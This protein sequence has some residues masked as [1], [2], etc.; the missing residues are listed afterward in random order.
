MVTRKNRSLPKKNAK[1]RN[2]LVPVTR[3]GPQQKLYSV[4]V[5]GTSLVLNSSAGGAIATVISAAA[6]NIVNWS[7]RFAS[8]FD[9]YR[10]L[11][12]MWKVTP[13]SNQPGLT[14]FYVDEN[15]SSVPTLTESRN[16]RHVILSNSNTASSRMPF[17][18]KWRN[19]DLSDLGFIATGTTSTTPAVLKVYT[20]ATLGTAAAVNAMWLVDMVFTVQLRGIQ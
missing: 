17:T 13:V 19:A 10:F 1:A 2:Y 12:V 7:T 3:T 20:D 9:E 4:I 14:Y 6:T 15:D 11:K 8:L 5:P 16:H 18:F